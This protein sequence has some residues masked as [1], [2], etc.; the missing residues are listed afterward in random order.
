MREPNLHEFVI[1]PDSTRRMADQA[2][3][4]LEEYAK[5]VA[6]SAPALA[7]ASTA[8]LR[9]MA[10]DKATAAERYLTD[11]RMQEL[12]GGPPR[13]RHERRKWA[14]IQRKRR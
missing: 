4:A 8:G 2:A 10:A 12:F 7:A 6:A 13:N 11:E 3:R 14:A 9:L 1:D 5:A